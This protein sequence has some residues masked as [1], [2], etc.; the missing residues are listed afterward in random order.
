MFLLEIFNIIWLEIAKKKSHVEKH[1]SRV[2]QIRGLSQLAQ[3]STW[4]GRK[5]KFRHQSVASST[6]KNVRYGMNQPISRSSR[7]VPSEFSGTTTKICITLHR[8]TFAVPMIRSCS[9]S[10]LDSPLFND[11]VL[12]QV[13]W[14]Q[15]AHFLS[16]V[17]SGHSAGNILWK[18]N[19]IFRSKPVSMFD[20]DSAF[21]SGRAKNK[22]KAKKKNQ[23][24]IVRL[25]DLRA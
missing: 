19:K 25:V 18:L 1:I 12:T 22:L 15:L 8:A 10:L 5:P 23:K 2:Y 3:F 13:L 7:H 9:N 20:S 16:R 21:E 11:R 17:V 14:R 24:L 6:I 4:F